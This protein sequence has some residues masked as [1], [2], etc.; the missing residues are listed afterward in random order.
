MDA[1]SMG[2]I[3][4]P[5]AAAAWLPLA[6]PLEVVGRARTVSN[7]FEIKA[8]PLLGDVTL[9]AL[10]FSRPRLEFQPVMPMANVGARVLRDF[11]VT[12]DARNHRLRLARPPAPIV[13]DVTP[14]PPPAP[15]SPGSAPSPR[16]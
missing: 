16:G 10:T 8:A 5:E 1:G 6:G 12:F 14:A 4:L 13:Q 3:V 15:R 2:G 9:G 7:S 11:A